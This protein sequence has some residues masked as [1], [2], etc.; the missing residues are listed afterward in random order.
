MR[1][2]E[3][4]IRSSIWPVAQPGRKGQSLGDSMDAS[5]YFT[6]KAAQCRRLATSVTDDRA[7]KALLALAEKYEARA[8]YAHHP[9]DSASA[10]S[11]VTGKLPTRRTA[12]AVH[13]LLTPQSAIST[14]SS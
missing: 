13:S 1:R 9:K 7:A 12:L 3:V 4:P 10:A 8:E 2:T 5:A 14:P 11:T 6:E